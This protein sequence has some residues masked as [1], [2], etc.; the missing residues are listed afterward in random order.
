MGFTVTACHNLGTL[1]NFR[2][3]GDSNQDKAVVKRQIS[4]P[5]ER[6]LSIVFKCVLW[7]L[8]VSYQPFLDRLDFADCSELSF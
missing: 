4:S 2:L 8:P 5:H 3:I 7:P 1:K 6:K